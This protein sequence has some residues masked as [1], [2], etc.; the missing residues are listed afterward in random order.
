[1]Q[2]SS[3]PLAFGDFGHFFH[4]LLRASDHRGA[5]PLLRVDALVG[6]H[7]GTTAAVLLIAAAAWSAVRLRPEGLLLAPFAVRAFDSH[8][9]WALA[10]ALAVLVWS[11]RTLAGYPPALSRA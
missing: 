1:V 7:I 3:D 4:V 5:P 9:K 6:E 2:V 10:L 8:T 11:Y